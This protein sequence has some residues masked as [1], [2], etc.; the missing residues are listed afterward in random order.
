MVIYNLKRWRSK[1]CNFLNLLDNKTDKIRANLKID[2]NSTVELISLS[3]KTSSSFYTLKGD[4]LKLEFL[5]NMLIS[6]K[7]KDKYLP[8]ASFKMFRSSDI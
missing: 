1:T 8:S 7:S 6:L 4:N 2:Y 3:S 5:L